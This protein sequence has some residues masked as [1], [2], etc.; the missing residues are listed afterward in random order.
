MN[1]LNR[2][3]PYRIHNGMACLTH[4]ALDN[5]EC[6]LRMHGLHIERGHI[7]IG[8]S[9]GCYAIAVRVRVDDALNPDIEKMRDLVYEC[10]GRETLGPSWNHYQIPFRSPYGGGTREL[11]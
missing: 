1:Y 9:L 6:W 4:Y 7:I 11:P 8:L 5:A 3:P 2:T 10:G